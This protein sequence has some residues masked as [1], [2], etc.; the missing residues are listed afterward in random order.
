MEIKKV[1]VLGCGLMGSGIVEVSARAGYE[2]TVLEVSEDLL[3]KGLA[4]IEKS[5]RRAVRK[6]GLSEDESKATH[7]RIKGTLVAGDLAG[8]DLF[9]EAVIENEAE[10]TKLYKEIGPIAGK[11]AI[12][13]S[14]T[15]SLSITSLAAASGRPERFLGLHF[16]NPV[17]VMN[18]V[19]V[20]A[21]PVTL[22]EILET[23]VEFVRK[24]GKEPVQAPDTCG[25]LVN[26]L[27]IPYLIEA[28]RLVE[29]KVATPEEID[30]AMTLGTGH[31]MGPLTLLD[32][33]GLDTTLYIAEVFFQEFREAR[34]APPP[35]LRRMVTIGHLGRKSGRG[36]YEYR[37]KAGRQ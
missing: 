27:L 22:P 11:E 33:V 12:F 34:F 4:R 14:N 32:F 24:L 5:L 26:R 23:G 25:F 7:G 3:E 21:S 10:K 1:A 17:P 31:P 29:A 6:G 37:A 36:F 35:L 19:E 13:A 20:V 8:S 18:L 2:T 16:F 15:S 9:I 28:V 30:K